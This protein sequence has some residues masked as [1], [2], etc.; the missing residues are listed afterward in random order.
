[1]TARD[2]EVSWWRELWIPLLAS[3]LCLVAGIAAWPLTGEWRWGLTGLIATITAAPLIVALAM[4][5]AESDSA[6]EGCMWVVLLLALLA[7]PVGL[8][9]W[10]WTGNWAWGIVALAGPFAAI[11]LAFAGMIVESESDR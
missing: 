10:L 9:V 7:V 4:I 3:A 6:F 11:F 5:F 2:A 1:M 8:T